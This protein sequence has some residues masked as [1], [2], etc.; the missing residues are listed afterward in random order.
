M[1][2]NQKTAAVKRHFD[3]VATRYDLMNTVL[4]FGLHHVWK[5]RAVRLVN[6]SPG[7]RVADLCGGTGDLA[8]LAARQVGP[9]GTVVLYDLNR[10]MMLAGQ[11]KLIR[12]A[13]KSRIWL[14]EGDVERL[15]LADGC[16]DAILVGFGVRNLARLEVGLREMHRVLKPG[17][18]LIILE[19][20]R[21]VNPLWRWLYDRYSFWIMPRLGQILA[22]S[23]EAYTYLITSIRQFPLPE[24]LA[25]FLRGAGFTQVSYHPLTNGIA[26][27]HRAVKED[28]RNSGGPA[29]RKAA[30]QEAK[31][32]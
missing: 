22:G 3:Q 8:L 19:F 29:E 11:P 18:R 7:E 14:V 32:V 5:R 27:I 10:A 4:S 9:A 15:A 12:S 23:R 20:S 2:P 28:R 26:M 25:R 1:E 13:L 17:G 6:L 16:L 21:P 31:R 30:A 24:E